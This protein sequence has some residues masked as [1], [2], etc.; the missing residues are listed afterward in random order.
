[1]AGS[2][3]GLLGRRLGLR[4]RVV[5]SFFRLTLPQTY[6]R[7]AAVLGDEL[8]APNH[9]RF[10]RRALPK[11]DAFASLVFFEEIN[12]GQVRSRLIC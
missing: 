6:A 8:R 3:V 1:M 5:G 2:A 12:S 7:A 9:F 4:R 10:N 11:S